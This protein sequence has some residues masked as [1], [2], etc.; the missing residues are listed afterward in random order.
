MAMAATLEGTTARPHARLGA[1]GI[2]RVAVARDMAEA[3]A[4]W[5]ACT[6]PDFLA[7]PYQRFE[8]L[9]AWYANI[10]RHDGVR[11]FV[12][13]AYDAADRPLLL[14]PLAVGRENGATVAR[15]MGG[16]HPTYNMAVWRRT[17]AASAT[18]IELDALTAA[19]RSHA[20]GVD[21]LAFTQQPRQWCGLS[22]PFAL[23]AGRP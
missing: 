18:K 11:P 1:T 10:G 2:A 9:A 3:E 12:V 5:R 6:G 21:V 17:F 16:K 23:F 19:I 8:L 4:V 22:N 15:F 7:T 13:T 14:L 20:E